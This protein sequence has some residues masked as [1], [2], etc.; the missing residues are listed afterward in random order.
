MSPW[1]YLGLVIIIVAVAL[2]VL[3]VSK[4]SE[5][6]AE[7]FDQHV[8]ELVDQE[9]TTGLAKRGVYHY[10][11]WSPQIHENLQIFIHDRIIDKYHKNALRPSYE[12]HNEDF[13]NQLYKKVSK[14]YMNDQNYLFHGIQDGTIHRD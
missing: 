7:S 3:L 2:I 9:I 10:Q 6:K 8:F 4:G 5:Q 12:A 11:W 13:L 1:I 14:A